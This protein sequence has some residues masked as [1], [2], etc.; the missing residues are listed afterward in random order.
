MHYPTGTIIH[1]TAGCGALAGTRYSTMCVARQMIG[2]WSFPI[3]IRVFY[4]QL[5]PMARGKPTG[6]WTR[7]SEGPQTNGSL[8]LLL[9]LLFFVGG[10]LCFFGRGGVFLFEALWTL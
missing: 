10:G 8:F 9:L 2:L 1:I 7:N 4:E 6:G 3:R 5:N